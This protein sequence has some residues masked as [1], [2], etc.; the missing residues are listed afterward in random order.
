MRPGRAR[1]VAILLM[2]AGMI[3]SATPA[4]A[5][6][7]L[8]QLVVEL[9]PGSRSRIDIEILNKDSERAYVAAEPREI[10]NPGTPAESQRDDPD[11]EKLGLLVSPS[12]MIL[13][14]GQRR[15]L[16]IA[17]I[18]PPSG[19]ERV[20]RVTVK[21]VVGELSAP[22]S[23]LKVLVGYDVLVLVRPENMKPHV[24]GIRSGNRLVLKNDGNVS[25]ELVDGKSCDAAGKSCSELPGSRL[26]AGAQK[27]VDVPAGSRVQY[28]LK[29]GTTT[30]PVQF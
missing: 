24:S 22:G 17:T 21:P 26:Y 2:F 29:V 7:L 20:Y 30:L 3:G 18:A 23:G 15:L 6:L 1:A 13:D 9:A 25:V 4:R 19:R 16:R 8:S 14:P 5:E 28:K 27:T 11:P 10:L 12:R